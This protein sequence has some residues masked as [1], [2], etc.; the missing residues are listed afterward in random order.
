MVA[1]ET[2]DLRSEFLKTA[3]ALSI[4]YVHAKIPN[5]IS[6]KK[7]C[8]KIGN[9]MTNQ[10]NETTIKFTIVGNQENSKGNPFPKLKMTG[11]QSW[12]PK[13]QRYGAWKQFVV[14]TLLFHTK[15]HPAYSMIVRN[16]G[17]TGKPFQTSKTLRARMD[18]MIRWGLEVH[19]DPENIFGSIADSLFKQDKWLAGS[20][21]FESGHG[22]G[23][24]EITITLQDNK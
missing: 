2:A 7:N 23:S 3:R 4:L 8:L 9:T 22:G 14:S 15:K 11:R 21:D 24:V 1:F 6:M 18:I 5:V 20:F 16:I 10:S 13:A 17:L 12:T 19:G